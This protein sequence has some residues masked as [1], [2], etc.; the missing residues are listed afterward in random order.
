MWKICIFLCNLRNA[1][2]Y[3]VMRT[4]IYDLTE[5]S[6]TLPMCYILFIL[7]PSNM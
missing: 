2:V 6:W 1:F 7:N 5:N 4:I 3:H